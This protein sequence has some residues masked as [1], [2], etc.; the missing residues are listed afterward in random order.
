MIT[1]TYNMTSAQIVAAINSNIKEIENGSTGLDWTT[2]ISSAANYSAFISAVN[3]ALDS[4]VTHATSSEKSHTD[5]SNTVAGA[6]ISG[7]NTNVTTVKGQADSFLAEDPPFFF[8]VM[9]LST[10]DDGIAKMICQQDSWKLCTGQNATKLYLSNDCGETWAY[11]LAWDKI[12]L[13]RMAWVFKNGGVLIGTKEN[14]I[15]FSS[16]LLSTLPEITMMESDGTTP[17]SFHSSVN[18]SYPGLYFGALYPKSYMDGDEEVLLIPSYWHAT[19]NNGATPVN[20]YHYKDDGTAKCVYKF[21][22]NPLERDDGTATGGATGNV[23]GNIANSAY[24]HHAHFAFRDPDTGKW[25]IQVGDSVLN[26]EIG[27]VEGT[28][29]KVTGAW[30]FVWHELSGDSGVFKMV[31]MIKD[32]SGNYFWCSDYTGMGGVYK[33]PVANFLSNDIIDHERVFV[34]PETPR[35]DTL[36]ITNFRKHMLACRFTSA[37]AIAGSNDFG[38]SWYIIPD[39]YSL[40][41]T[42]FEDYS[43]VRT[44]WE[45]DDNGWYLI[46]FKSLV[47]MGVAYS[48]FVK[49]YDKPA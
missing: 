27:I 14:K 47:T 49:P 7:V 32:N 8:D 12:S 29:N 25:Y 38:E 40:K 1:L 20:L 23:I 42:A 34:N 15:Y 37:P 24:C 39:F 46:T 10:P 16:D 30:T 2:P 45:R 11:S 44:A 18:A 19:D 3:T 36:S 33:V 48:V 17:L 5:I 28:Y 6:L 9:Q 41:T 35:G 26:H 13:I 22:D 43:A 21:G 4:V 31:G